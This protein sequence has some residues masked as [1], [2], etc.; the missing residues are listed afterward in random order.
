MPIESQ[1]L[2]KVIERE[3]PDGILLGFGGQ[4]ALNAGMDLN[5]KGVLS[6]HK[7]KVLGTGTAA[8]EAADN[9]IKFRQLMIEKGLPIPKS[10]GAN[11]VEEAQAA[12]REIGFPVM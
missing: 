3:R 9:R 12:A 1:F 7:V 2:E 6:K 11:T 8:I 5:E 10:W 4:T